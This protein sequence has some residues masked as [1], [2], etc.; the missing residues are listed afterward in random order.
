MRVG[1]SLHQVRALLLGV[2]QHRAEQ[3]EETV[4]TEAECAPSA[5][6]VLAG[7]Y[8]LERP[9]GPGGRA[10]RLWFG[11]D[12]VLNRPVAVKVDLRDSPGATALMDS[13]VATGQAAHRNLASVYDADHL[14]DCTYVVREWVEGQALPEL[15]LTDGPPEPAVAAQL[16]RSVAEAVAGAHAQGVA[17][18]N[19]HPANVLVT[20]DGHAKVTDLAG[21]EDRTGDVRA[22]GAV[23]YATLTGRWP[24]IGIPGDGL[25]AAP[26]SDEQTCSPRQ[27]RAGV[28]GSLSALAMR[29]LDPPAS[30][31]TAA[32]LAAELSRHGDDPVTGPIPVVEQEAGYGY[33]RRR[34]SGWVIAGVVTA[35]VVIAAAGWALGV[36]LGA[37]PTP[38]GLGYPS[39]SAAGPSGQPTPSGAPAASTVIKP[40]AAR[41][42]DPQG[43]GTELAGAARAIDGNPATAWVTQTYTT[44][45][46]GGLKNG[47]GVLVD[48]GSP[49]P[50]R[51]VTVTMVGAGTSLQ[52][53]TS[54]TESGDP[55]A[56]QTVAT[57]NGAGTTVTFTPAA[58]TTGQYW[59]LWITRLAPAGG[60]Y[61]AGVAEVVFHR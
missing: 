8:R 32:G 48:L 41:I 14:G 23:L 29:A 17:H 49:Q 31:L 33:A 28:P 16:V 37:I 5:G 58:P 15:L 22:L 51:S 1:S 9:V 12:E 45:N 55:A 36:N 52:L 38:R 35:L 40:V 60:G 24:D 53:R 19:L 18:G 47:M 50:V 43:D 59:L 21:G 4:S 20:A 54:N 46:F 11:V 57:A 6:Q 26:L 39:F 30:G 2:E 42:L 61:S 34:R 27:V 44:A 25:P 13:A 10:G 7:R 56:Y 3:P